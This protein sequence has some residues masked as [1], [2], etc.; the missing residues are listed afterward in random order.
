MYRT[1][2]RVQESKI[3]VKVKNSNFLL[4]VARIVNFRLNKNKKLR[5][6]IDDY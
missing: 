4:S 6:K 5:T 3:T 1:G 2:K